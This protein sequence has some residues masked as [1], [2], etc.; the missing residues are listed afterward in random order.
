MSSSPESRAPRRAARPDLRA[1]VWTRLGDDSVLGDEVTE[2]T[3]GSLAERTRSA[4]RAQGYAVGWA[5]G[6]REALARAAEAAV[7]ASQQRDRSEHQRQDEHDAALDA[8]VL[9]ADE[10]QRAV[11]QV[12]ADIGDQATE[13][14]LELTREL[15]GRELT[16]SV[17]PGADVVRRVLAVLPTDAVAQV[18]MHPSTSVSSAVEDLAKRGVSV[19]PDAELQPGDAVV[20]TDTSVLDLRISTALARLRDVLA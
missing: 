9:A 7:V 11:Q 17:D 12:C 4:A 1:G 2:A 18:R 15:V 14:A 19:L 13:L 10:L 5:E 20:E 3:L 8:L 16:T 6:R